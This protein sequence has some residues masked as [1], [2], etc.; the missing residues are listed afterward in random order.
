MQESFLR[1][2]HYIEKGEEVK[3]VEAFLACVARN[4][5][6]DLNRRARKHLREDISAEELVRPDPAPGPEQVVANLDYVRRTT[7]LLDRL[8]GKRARQV[9]HLCCFDEMTHVEIAKKLSVSVATVQ[10]DY[11]RAV[12]VLSMHE[13]G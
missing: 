12:F 6:I 9:F 5:F 1:L 11:A 3:E 8:A 10:R 4:A 2:L 13:L 7:H